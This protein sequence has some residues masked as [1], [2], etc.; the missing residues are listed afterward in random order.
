MGLTW[1]QLY[2]RRTSVAIAES[3]DLGAVE[4]RDY[5]VVVEFLHRG[6]PVQSWVSN[7]GEGVDFSR[8]CRNI[9]MNEPVFAE[10]YSRVLN[11]RGADTGSILILGVDHH[12]HQDVRLDVSL[13]RK[14][15][16]KMLGL[17]KNSAHRWR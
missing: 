11:V 9:E 8:T 1:R 4:E 13:M 10:N 3:A 5:L 17:V 6:K 14:S 2:T 16:G 15:D 12:I 7:F